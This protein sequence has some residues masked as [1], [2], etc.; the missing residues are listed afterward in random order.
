MTLR[1]ILNFGE[2][3]LASSF[4]SL[5]CVLA[6]LVSLDLPFWLYLALIIPFINYSTKL[7]AIEARSDRSA[8]R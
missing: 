8:K 2:K 6:V 4:V 1:G 5:I 7:E 3:F